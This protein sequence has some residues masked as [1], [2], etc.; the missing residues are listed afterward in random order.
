[1][2]GDLLF[3]LLIAVMLTSAGWYLSK[4]GWTAT[5]GY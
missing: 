3:A 5:G 4:N 2:A 1:V